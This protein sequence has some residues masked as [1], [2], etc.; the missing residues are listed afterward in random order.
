MVNLFKIFEHMLFGQLCTKNYK[1]STVNCSLKDIK[2][3]NKYKSDINFEFIWTGSV[4]DPFLY[5]IQN[6]EY[7][8]F[9]FYFMYLSLD[10]T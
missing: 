7:D 8:S 9:K 10:L 4:N 6:I 3:L 1:R 5:L 2:Q